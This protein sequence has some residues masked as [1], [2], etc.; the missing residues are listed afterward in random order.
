MCGAKRERENIG[1]RAIF[2]SAAMQLVDG[3]VDPRC[4]KHPA[5]LDNVRVAANS[6]THTSPS[7]H[8]PLSL[9]DGSSSICDDLRSSCQK[10]FTRVWEERNFLETEAKGLV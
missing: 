4:P 1:Q 2:I 7:F 5:L 8:S 3:H 6:L 10:S 9:G